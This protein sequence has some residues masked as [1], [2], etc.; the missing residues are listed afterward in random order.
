MSKGKMYGLLTGEEREWEKRGKIWKI[1]EGEGRLFVGVQKR[2][3]TFEATG[4][5]LVRKKVRSRKGYEWK[6]FLGSFGWKS[7]G[8]SKS[9]HSFPTVQVG[10]TLDCIYEGSWAWRVRPNF[11]E[12]DI[13]N[14]RS[15]IRHLVK[16][17]SWLA[18]SNAKFFW[19]L[20][21]YKNE[22]H[23]SVLPLLQIKGEATIL[24][25][26]FVQFDWM[27]IKVHCT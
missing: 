12:L 27:V 25:M 11:S 21:I 8:L 24:T 16:F 13:C 7:A 3:G 6:K 17:I 23:W 5:P 19:H 9:L 26:Y 4:G 20:V 14:L 2:R 22:I 15:K 18:F 10:S 1:G